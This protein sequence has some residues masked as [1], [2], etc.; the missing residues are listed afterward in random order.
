[1]SMI[2]GTPL[3]NVRELGNPERVFDRLMEL[4]LELA[5]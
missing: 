3:T 5:E 2:D 4:M 1:M